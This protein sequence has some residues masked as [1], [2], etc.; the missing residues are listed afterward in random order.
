MPKLTIDRVA[1][2]VEPGFSILQACTQLGIEIPRFCYHERLSVA[3]NCRMCL[4]EV[5][6]RPKLVASCAEVCV[7]GLVVHT[8]SGRVRMARKG[9]M[10]MLLLNHP[11]DCPIC[12]QAGECDLQDQAV[13]YGFD[14]GRYDENKRAVGE[15]HLGPLIKTAMTRCILCSRCVRFANE[16]AGIP[17]LGIVGRGEDCEVVPYLDQVVTSELSGNLIDICPVGALT[18]RPYAF[19]A[20]PWEL[21]KTET[22]DVLDAFGSNIRVDSIGGEVM[23]V[24]PRLH[25][26]VNQEWISD[27]TRFAYDGLKRQRLDSPYVKRNGQLEPASWSEAFQVMAQ[28]LSALPGERVAALSGDL[29]D[30]ESMVALRDLMQS[31]GSPHMDCRQDGARFDPHV[32]A[33][34][35]FNSTVA[36]IEQA[37]LI[38]LIA[39]DPRNEAPLLNARIRQRFRRGGLTVATL[40]AVPDLTYPCQFLGADSQTLLSLADGQHR[41]CEQL[42]QARNPLLIVGMGALVRRD[43][44]AVHAHAR[45]LA[46]THGMIRDRWNGFNVLHTAAARIGALDLG[47]VPQQSGG[48]DTKGILDGLRQGAI[49]VLYLLGADEI[50]PLERTASSMVIYQGHHG[51]VGAEQADVILPGAAYTEKH[52]TYVNIE[53]RVQQ[54][55]PATFPP[56][57]AQEDW[58]ILR[59]LSQWVGCALPY[60]S[61]D[62]VRERLVEAS[63][64]FAQ[65]DE[66]SPAPW[67]DFAQL[68]DL[69]PA[70]FSLPQ[71][72]FYQT[73][74]ISRASATMAAC[75]SSFTRGQL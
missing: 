33:G 57:Q 64:T 49:E 19:R 59:M 13:G 62:Q 31:L 65:L 48:R 32:R 16:V 66:V 75:V 43:G 69:D 46:Q 39:S 50:G 30:A 24:L 7:E 8:S 5:E 14:R 18:S 21:R 45:R 25:E 53:G 37:D 58:K 9:V 42:L 29:C 52:G 10:E 36:G 4:V 71:R 12:D 61:L 27:K 23:R 47:F 26:D 28:R 22:I 54:A 40:G 35:L 17:E 72:G 44:M 73:D 67:Q 63:A 11:L 74:P 2:E 6:R 51:D 68:G 60:N 34:Y 70:P 56:G 15:K 55:R 20:R 1:V 3:A 41:F 38:L